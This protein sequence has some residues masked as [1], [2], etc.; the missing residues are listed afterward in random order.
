MRQ[1]PETPTELPFASLNQIIEAAIHSGLEM[2]LARSIRHGFPPGGQVQALEPKV[3]VDEAVQTDEGFS[4]LVS[5]T[6]S[7]G[8]SQGWGDR[9]SMPH[10][11]FNR[12]TISIIRCR[13]KGSIHRISS[14][15]FVRP[16]GSPG[17]QAGPAHR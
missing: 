13:S 16:L 7:R 8:T 3:R 9:V 4:K 2:S 10:N 15:R 14:I 12:S 17:I 1:L 6:M 11:T 5:K